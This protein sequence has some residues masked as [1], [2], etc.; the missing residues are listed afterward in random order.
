MQRIIGLVS[1]LGL[2]SG[3]DISTQFEN[4]SS[5]IEDFL[6]ANN[7]F[8]DIVENIENRSKGKVTMAK[9]ERDIGSGDSH[10]EFE[11]VLDNGGEQEYIFNTINNE[12]FLQKDVL[13]AFISQNQL[14]D[15]VQILEKNTGGKL[16]EAE[17][18]DTL[19]DGTTHIELDIIMPDGS[20]QEYI[21]DTVSKTLIL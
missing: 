17:F 1:L 4:E 6:S 20:E 11:V 12:I 18:E 9:F 21:F 8:V 19:G 3:C 5:N 13:E 7:Q 10:I 14:L 2:L 16:V 15:L